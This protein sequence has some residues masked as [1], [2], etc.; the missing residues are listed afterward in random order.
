MPDPQ[1]IL[2]SVIE[3][4]SAISGAERRGLS[5]DADTEIYKQLG[6]Y[7][8]D[9][10]FG[11][12]GW[13]KREFDVPPDVKMSDYVPYESNFRWAGRLFRHLLRLPEP[14][15][16]SLKIRDVV[17]AIERRSWQPTETLFSQKTN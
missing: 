8:D 14:Q 13:V 2:K 6:I 17:A 1:A 9:F 5:V 12:V 7:G 11:L 4:V 15:F 10:V 16:K 3:Q